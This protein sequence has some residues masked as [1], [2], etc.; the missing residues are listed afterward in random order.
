MSHY[1]GDS[2]A[3]IV[4]N[5]WVKK[6]SKKQSDLLALIKKKS[7]VSEYM[8]PNELSLIKDISIDSRKAKSVLRT[9]LRD[10]SNLVSFQSL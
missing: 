7:T 6:K 10:E 2:Q 9:N 8:N 4:T 3:T 1:Q 5:K